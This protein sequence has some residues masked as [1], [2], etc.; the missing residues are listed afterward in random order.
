MALVSSSSGASWTVAAAPFAAALARRRPECDDEVIAPTSHEEGRIDTGDRMLSVTVA[1]LLPQSLQLGAKVTAA[2]CANERRKIGEFRL[3]LDNENC[4]ACG[5]GCC[6][7]DEKGKGGHPLCW[8]LAASFEVAV[9]CIGSR[10][11]AVSFFVLPQEGDGLREYPVA[12]AA[13]GV[14]GCVKLG[15]LCV[16]S[17]SCWQ[18]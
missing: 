7:C 11:W 1:L 4:T 15:E 12:I 16:E 10:G 13:P 2:G 3:R 6:D 14:V 17:K 8:A 18:R 5:R 9:A